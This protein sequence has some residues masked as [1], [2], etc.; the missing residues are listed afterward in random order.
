MKRLIF[1]LCSIFTIT[2]AFADTNICRKHNAAVI[3]LKRSTDGQSATSDASAKTWSVTFNYTTLAAASRNV[4]T[5]TGEAACN[6]ISGTANT[7]NTALYTTTSDVGVNC[8]CEML[9]PAHSYWTF[10]QAY[11]SEAACASGCASNCATLVNTSTAF[12]T[13]LFNSIW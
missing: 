2:V 12:R 1:I 11:A 6:S 9:T 13:G 5:I 3:L 4:S 10:T 7:A 8:W